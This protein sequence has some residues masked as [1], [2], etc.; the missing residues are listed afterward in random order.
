MGTVM[1]ALSDVQGQLSDNRRH[2]GRGLGRVLVVIYGILALAAT[3][4]GVVQLVTHGD[5]APLAYGL[6]VAAGAIYIVA[7]VA[8]A[9]DGRWRPIAWTSVTIELVGVL[10]VG[11]ASLNT[12][13]M[14]PDSTVWSG[15]GKGYGWV[16]LVL[17]MVGMWWLWRTRTKSSET[18]E[19]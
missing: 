10:V 1:S 4:R 15:F 13:D 9:L 17:P 18:I 16:P 3:A 12:P 7:T 8:L 19:A 14:F 11:V 5:Q 6:S 2:S